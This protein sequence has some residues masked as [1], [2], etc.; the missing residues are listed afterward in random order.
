[1]PTWAI[2]D[3]P[4]NSANA[5][6]YL[7][8]RVPGRWHH[9]GWGLQRAYIVELTSQSSSSAL[10][11]LA[12]ELAAFLLVI[13]SERWFQELLKQT[14]PAIWHDDGPEVVAYAVQML[15][16]DVGGEHARLNW[17]TARI[18]QFLIENAVVHL[19][20]LRT[21]WLG[22]VRRQ[23]QAVLER[24]VDQLL[25]AQEYRAFVRLL[26]QLIDAAPSHVAMVHLR[27]TSARWLVFEDEAGHSLAEDLLGELAPRGEPVDSLDELAISALVS[28]A[29]LRVRYHGQG[30]SEHALSTIRDV[31][32]GRF[33]RCAGC[34][35]CARV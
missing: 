33:E 27:T 21:F 35:R 29:P 15:H 22:V 20:G 14:Y 3:D 7:A 34:T 9:R 5:G 12:R 18:Y 28:L 2:I 1:M 30:I 31:F 17:A 8:N 26:R 32:G 24:A 10:W 6:Q 4:N 11:T 13:D 23:R 16:D 19:D 25:L